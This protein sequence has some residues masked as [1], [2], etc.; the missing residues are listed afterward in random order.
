MFGT[1]DETLAR[2]FDI[3]LQCHS[4]LGNGC[5]TIF[6]GVYFLLAVMV[7]GEESRLKR[8]N[9][10]AVLASYQPL[11]TALLV[12]LHMISGAKVMTCSQHANTTRLSLVSFRTLAFIIKD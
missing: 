9:Y 2:V 4:K 6:N 12:T 3:L 11:L 8:A 1:P 10:P 7:E 5:L